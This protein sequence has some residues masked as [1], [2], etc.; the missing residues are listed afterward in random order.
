MQLPASNDPNIM[1]R[2]AVLAMET[3]AHTFHTLVHAI[4][5]ERE[6]APLVTAEDHHHRKAAHFGKIASVRERDHVS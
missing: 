3:D 6:D 4:A 2:A 1:R 5:L